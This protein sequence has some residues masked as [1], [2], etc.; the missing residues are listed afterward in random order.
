MKDKSDIGLIGLAVMGENLVLNMESKGFTVSVFNRTAAKTEAFMANQAK[1]KN[2]RGF[3][4][5]K[6][7]VESLEKP[8]KVMLMVKAGAPVDAM[9]GQV[10][11]FLDKGDI[12]IDGGNSY[13]MD[14]RRR[15]REM[16]EKGFRFIGTGVSGGEE[17]AL[18]G[19]CIM[20]GGSKDAYREVEPILT[21]IAAQVD[22]PCCVY[23]GDNDAGHYVKMVHNGIEYGDMQMIAE[24]YDL[25]QKALGMTPHEI[26]PIFEEWN[27]GDLDSYL[28]EIS[29]DILSKDDPDTGKSM[30]DIIQDKAGQKGTGMWTSRSSLE[31][32]V[33]VPSIY[34]AVSSRQISGYKDER[35][36]AEKVLPGPSAK[37]T[38]DR[39]KFIQAVHDALLAS[40]ICSYAQ[41]MVLMKE[42]AKEF[43]FELNYREIAQIWKGGCII[44][45]V[46]LDRIKEAYKRN[47]D[48]PNMLVDEDF[49]KTVLACQDNWRWA[50]KTAIELGVPYLTTAASLSYFDQ[51]RTGRLSANMIQA[52]RD[53]FGAHTY[54]RT[55][56]EGWYHTDWLNV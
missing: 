50:V 42:A 22:G 5:M 14:T 54:E 43:G 55:D 23:I 27:K 56:K 33:P 47:P 45:A 31:L 26:Q 38:G 24:A 2:I 37:F 12:L 6:Q 25:L 29:A 8:R 10:I 21:K 18:K 19:P 40:K 20:P 30:V 36:E 13:F 53:Y 49:S 48:L 1:G 7:F 46:F 52:Q 17:G 41:G 16:E 9:M 15:C 51:Y 4:D 34:T 32:G 44:R 3:T 28:M 39:D 35:V 11:S